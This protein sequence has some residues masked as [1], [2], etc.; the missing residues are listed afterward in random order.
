MAKP[1]L[2]ITTLSIVYDFSFIWILGGITSPPKAELTESTLLVSIHKAVCVCVCLCACVRACA[3]VRV[4]L[5]DD[6]LNM[7]LRW[8]NYHPGFLQKRRQQDDQISS[9]SWCGNCGVKH[10]CETPVGETTAPSNSGGR[11]IWSGDHQLWRS[12]NSPSTFEYL[13]QHPDRET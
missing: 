2:P 6:W 3:C 10:S 1:R 12:R 7:I 11:L 8:W 13:S 9:G 4:C 5:C